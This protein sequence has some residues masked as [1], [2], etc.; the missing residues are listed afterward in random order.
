MENFLDRLCGVKSRSP[1]SA[2][3]QANCVISGDDKQPLVATRFVPIAGVPAR[4]KPTFNLCPAFA[5]EETSSFLAVE[6]Y[7]FQNQLPLLTHARKQ[8]LRLCAAAIRM[9][10]EAGDRFDRLY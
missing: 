5:Y 9:L 4:A 2:C 8:Q 10:I 1:R 3:G 6:H 7:Y